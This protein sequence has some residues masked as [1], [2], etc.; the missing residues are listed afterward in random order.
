[1][2]LRKGGA[3]KAPENNMS[4]SAP[5]KGGRSRKPWGLI[6]WVVFF[7][8]IFGLFL[9]NREK[10]RKTLKDTQFFERVL[11][12]QVTDTDIE[13][14]L[15]PV[16]GAGQAGNATEPEKPRAPETPPPRRVTAEP[17]PEQRDAQDREL[18]KP[19]V[20]Q[21]PV[22]ASTLPASPPA[23]VNPQAVSRSPSQTQPPP[24]ASQPPMS[25]AL[26]EKA[27][28]FIRIDSDGAILRTKVTRQLP[29]SDSPMVDAL[30]AL[31]SG[32]NAEE[33]SKGLVSLIPQGTKILNATVRGSTAYINF[34]EDFQ[35]ITSGVEGYAAALRQVVWTATEFSN[36]RDVQILIEGRRMDYLGEIIWIGSPVSRE[37]L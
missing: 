26:R 30:G 22:P 29:V 19:S 21:P 10:I 18:E 3:A 1:M 33:Q 25:P 36:V 24:A 27:L 16:P 17:A 9:I 15:L 11:N 6:F 8:V 28:Y 13:P 4:Q 14:P 5:K 31:I 7:I 35:F 37:M 2:A 34:S 12:R 23:A 20:D 32:P